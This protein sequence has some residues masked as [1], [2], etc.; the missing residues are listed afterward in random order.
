MPSVADHRAD[1]ILGQIFSPNGDIGSGA[2]LGGSFR[3]EQARSTSCQ[4]AVF[5]ANCAELRRRDK[6]ISPI[7]GSV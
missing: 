2:S 5:A 1:A 7:N 3:V 6:A 4:R